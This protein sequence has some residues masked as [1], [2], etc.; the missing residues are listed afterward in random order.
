VSWSIRL[1]RVGGIDVRVH[2]SFVLI[3]LW[4]AYAWASETGRGWQGALFGLVATLLLFGAVVLHELAHGWQARRFGIP[5]RD[6]TLWPIGGIT[7]MERAPTSPGQDLRI[8][9][10][11]PLANLA[12][13]GALTLL[14]WLLGTWGPLGA[15]D[16]RRA[17]G[18]VS[19]PGLLAYLVV[20]NVWLALFNL[21]PA[22]P[23][24][25]GRALRALL[26]TRLD[27]V[28][29]TRRAVAVGQTLAWLMGLSG[30]LSGSLT[31]VAVAVFVYLASAGES[32][33]VELR[34]ALGSLRV[35]QAMSRGVATLDSTDPLARAVDLTLATTQASF[36]VVAGDRVVGLLSDRDLLAGLGAGGPGRPVHAAM[37]AGPPTA[38]PDESLLDAEER[39]ASAGVAA[40]PI[41]DGGR[42]VGLLTAADVVEARRLL[43][44]G[45]VR[46]TAPVG[47][48][49]AEQELGGAR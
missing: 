1:L 35:D 27:P 2:V 48:R 38:R 20:A 47:P 17:L 46:R 39:M 36:P 30:L 40:L 8:A 21:L 4:A 25:G 28:A 26:A 41:V 29:A 13:A 14:A 6:V 32:A 9:L 15:G 33:L 37:R 42:L 22:F 11:G 5:I 45:G 31:L 24:D 12:V 3:L 43:T 44:P 18:E 7:R 49:G 23:L 19:W 34:T 10:V 16:V